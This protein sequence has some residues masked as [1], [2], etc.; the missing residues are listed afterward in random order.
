MVFHKRESTNTSST[1]WKLGDYKVLLVLDGNK[2]NEDE[3]EDSIHPMEYHNNI[4]TCSHRIRNNPSTIVT[5]VVVTI[6]K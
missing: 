1:N 4:N 6:E 2:Y 5:S 3:I